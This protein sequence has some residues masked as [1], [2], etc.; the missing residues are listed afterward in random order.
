MD[1]PSDFPIYFFMGGALKYAY[2]VVM[3]ETG[4]DDY[5]FSKGNQPSHT[6]ILWAYFMILTLIVCVH[7]LNML[8][9]IMGES[10]SE[11]KESEQI[12]RI[13]EHLKFVLYN[14][15]LDPLREEKSCD[16][17]NYLLSAMLKTKMAEQDEMERIYENLEDM[18][19]HKDTSLDA[20][21]FDIQNIR[22]KMYNKKA[23]KDK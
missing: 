8:I 23:A 18:T 17:T 22:D 5:N 14:W 13:R 2:L 16:A 12:N 1:G 19:E 6:T 11:N 20:V 10:F 21:L 9:A 4:V 15:M 7:M 3:G